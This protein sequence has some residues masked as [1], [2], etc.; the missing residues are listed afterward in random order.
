MA[1]SYSKKETAMIIGENIKAARR[2]RGLTQKEVASQFY[3]TQQQY[4][5]WEA[6]VYELNYDQILKLCDV[7]EISPN[8]IFG[9]NYKL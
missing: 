9:Y 2:A 1:K 4:S 3:M 7:L 5:R 6:G 8:E